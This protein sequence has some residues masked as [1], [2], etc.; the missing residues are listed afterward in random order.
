MGARLAVGFRFGRLMVLRRVRPM[1]P[2]KW[3]VQC[4]CG[5]VKEISG[6]SLRTGRSNSCGCLR[7]DLLT[8]RNM[9]A[10]AA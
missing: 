2:E 6:P 8:D 4:D 7:R 3:V 5:T 1:K 9:K 10:K